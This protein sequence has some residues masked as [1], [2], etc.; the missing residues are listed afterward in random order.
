MEHPP[1]PAD[2]RTA[3][4]GFLAAL[5]GDGRPLLALVGLGL[6]LAGSVR[7]VPCGDGFLSAAGYRL[8]PVFN[9]DG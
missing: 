4:E 3:S 7:T 8:E 1:D 6:I 5:V 2:P 9:F